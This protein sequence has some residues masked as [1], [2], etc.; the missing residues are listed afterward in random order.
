MSF[1]QNLLAKQSAHI[2][3]SNIKC[4][5]NCF[6]RKSNNCYSKDKTLIRRKDSFGLVS[7]LSN[8]FLCHCWPDKI[9]LER[10]ALAQFY[11]IRESGQ[12]LPLVELLSVSNSMCRLQASLKKLARGTQSSL[13]NPTVSKEEKGFYNFGTLL[14]KCKNVD[15]IDIKQIDLRRI[16]SLNHD[17]FGTT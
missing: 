12:S 17:Y 6:P 13:F 4:I 14:Q 1:G 11:Y 15:P 3:P 5:V 10:L 16:S 2:M 9:K 8:F 7:M